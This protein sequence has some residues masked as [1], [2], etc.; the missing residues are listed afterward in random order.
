MSLGFDRYRDEV[1]AV[2][3]EPDLP[4]ALEIA[5]ETLSAFPDRAAEV[6]DWIS[7]IHGAAGD[8]DRALE[9]L[10]DGLEHGMWW[11][12]R[13][14]RADPDLDEARKLDGFEALAT[15]SDARWR[16]ASLELE[17]IVRLSGPEA[18]P[19]LIVMHGW[20]G[21]GDDLEHEWI[22]AA[23][24]AGVTMA[25]AVPAQWESSDRT[26]RYWA[27]L[28]E[29]K[30]DVASILSRISW[31]RPIDR[32]AIAGFS[33]AGGFAVQLTGGGVAPNGIVAIGPV[34]G[35]AIDDVMVGEDA[36]IALVTG[37][38]DF[39]R[40]DTEGLAARLRERGVAHTLEVVP[41]IGHEV[42]ASLGPS[43]GAAVRFAL[44]IDD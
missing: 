13:L 6:T 15:A 11:S 25:Y 2:Y 43:M 39:A 24:D 5:Q 44:E 10:R 18:G 32:F 22:P 4:R 37:E 41:G 33:R 19:L 35:S 28:E 38:T 42:N 20:T 36:R 34:F 29:S 8:H 31:E 14:L 12:P 1:F 16:A 40:A 21:A 7:C 26:R 30:R 23:E 17:P 9:T 3:N 27:E